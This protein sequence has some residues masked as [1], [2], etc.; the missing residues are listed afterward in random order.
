MSES[1]I[2]ESELEEVELY[3]AKSWWT[4]KVFSQVYYL[5]NFFYPICIQTLN[6]HRIAI[7]YLMHRS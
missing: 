3:H 1:I 4:E 5:R 2:P 6:Y 7:F